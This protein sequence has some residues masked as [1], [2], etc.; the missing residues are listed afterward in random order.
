MLYT[1][2]IGWKD[3]SVKCGG[4]V[5]LRA[6]TTAEQ[7]KGRPFWGRPLFVFPG[8]P[9]AAPLPRGSRRGRKKDAPKGVPFFGLNPKI[10]R[11]SVG[12]G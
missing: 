3:G 9:A 2:I 10:E 8:W 4:A 1:F 12:N 5:F 7:E 11:G 6:K